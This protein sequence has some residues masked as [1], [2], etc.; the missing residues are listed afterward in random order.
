MSLSAPAPA[1]SANLLIFPLDIL[2]DILEFLEADFA[3]LFQCTLTSATIAAISRKILFRNVV[4]GDGTTALFMRSLHSNPSLSL[5][6]KT[7]TLSDTSLHN[8]MHPLTRSRACLSF[9]LFV[10][11]TT[12][13][14][15]NLSFRGVNDI[16][17]ILA[18]IPSLQNLRVIDCFQSHA[19]FIRGQWRLGLVSPSVS[20]PQS[21]VEVARPVSLPR[22]R[23]LIINGRCFLDHQRLA[24]VVSAGFDPEVLRHL[25]IICEGTAVAPYWWMPVLRASRGSLRT[26]LLRLDDQ[27]VPPPALIMASSVSLYDGPL[28]EYKGAA[29]NGA[30]Y[31]ALCASLERTPSPLPALQHL[32]LHLTDRISAGTRDEQGSHDAFATRLTSALLYRKAERYPSFTRLALFLTAPKSRG[33]E[34]GEKDAFAVVQRWYSRLSRFKQTASGVTV[35]VRF[36]NPH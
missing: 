30:F 5:L 25:E 9:E 15:A 6:V 32:R 28:P 10:N 36:K 13:T 20:L 12:L 4:L 8:P 11:L 24:Q 21:Q 1:P 33:S 7:I 31:D 34:R 19:P 26:L 17:T 14:L 29:G 23:S 18:L 22:L 2:Y 27:E 3:T 35:E 16:I